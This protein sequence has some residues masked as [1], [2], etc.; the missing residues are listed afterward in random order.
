[1]KAYIIAK[2]EGIKLE[3]FK[4]IESTYNDYFTGEEMHICI[5]FLKIAP[6]PEILHAPDSTWKSFCVKTYLDSLPTEEKNNIINKLKSMEAKSDFYKHEYGNM[7][8][9]LLCSYHEEQKD[10]ITVEKIVQDFA[11][12]EVKISS[13]EDAGKMYVDGVF[14]TGYESYSTWL[15]YEWGTDI[16]TFGKGPLPTVEVLSENQIMFTVFTSPFYGLGKEAYRKLSIMYPDVEFVVGYRSDEDDN[17]YIDGEL[18]S[19]SVFHNGN[20]TDF[21]HEDFNNLEDIWTNFT[22]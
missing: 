16:Y 1:M 22:E 14:E 5:D 15:V 2:K 3:D 21:E 13:I 12:W 19:L 4:P 6:P 18:Y 8:D 11:E 17:W 7:Y 10:I 20:E 9:T